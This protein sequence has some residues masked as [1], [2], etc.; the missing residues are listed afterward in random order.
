MQTVLYHQR[1]YRGPVDGTPSPEFDAAISKFKASV[2]FVER[3]FFTEVTLKKMDITPDLFS[4]HPAP[5]M[6]EM[7]RYLGMHEKRNWLDLS[8]WLKSDGKTLGDPSKLPWCGDAVETAIKLTLGRDLFVKNSNPALVE[9]PYW[10]L[11]WLVFGTKEEVF[12]RPLYGAVAVFERKGGGHVGFVAGYDHGRQRLLIRGGNQSDTV[13]DAWMDING[14]SARLRGLRWPVTE[15]SLPWKE[16]HRVY[17]P[18]LDSKN[19]R[20]ETVLT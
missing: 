6:N 7:A 14:S 11:N 2:G 13:S 1:F 3:P 8:T 15:N 16:A 5:W 17:A 10:A 20:V 9:N 12:P 19:N 18:L 4:L